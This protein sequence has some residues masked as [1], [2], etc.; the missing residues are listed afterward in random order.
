MR[1]L[2]TDVMIDL[3]RGFAPAV[4]WFESL[5]DEEAPALPGFV[6]REL[7]CG[8]RHGTE[9]RTLKERVQPFRIYWPR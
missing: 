8:C 7:I 9:L 6:V 3:L 2:D 1:L 4:T 5:G